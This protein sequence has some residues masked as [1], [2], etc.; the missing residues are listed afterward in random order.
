M[1]AAA[2]RAT[3][4]AVMDEI[5]RRITEGPWG[6][7]TLLPGEIEL[8]AEFGCSRATVN[9]A[10]SELA[11]QGLIDRRRK[12]GTRVRSTPIRQAR[13]ELPLVRAEIERTGAVYRYA[14]VLREEV[15][16]PAWLSSRMNLPAGAPVL[17][18][19]CVHFADGNPY[20]FE[21]RWI[22]VTALPEALAQDF[23]TNGPNEWLVTTVP[24]SQVEV[25]LTAVAADSLVAAYLDQ[26][27]GEAVFRIERGTWWQGEAITFVTLSHATGFRMTTRY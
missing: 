23:T 24:F 22:N 21:D 26:R 16:A 2:P 10:L 27:P 18:L 15:A 12:S 7:G 1:E 5:R 9:R 20:Q 17:H 11:A 14:L 6:P 4:R 8:A 25:G 3:F 19:H 13:F